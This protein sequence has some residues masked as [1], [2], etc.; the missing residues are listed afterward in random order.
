MRSVAVQWGSLPGVPG[1][2]LLST[3]ATAQ[4]Q[5]ASLTLCCGSFKS[6][7]FILVLKSH[8][9]C[10]NSPCVLYHCIARSS[11]YSV[12]FVVDIV[13]PRLFILSSRERLWV[14]RVVVPQRCTSWVMSSSLF[15]LPHRHPLRGCGAGS[16]WQQAECWGL[17]FSRCLWTCEQ[18]WSRPHGS[19]TRCL[20]LPMSR[21]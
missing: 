11:C 9:L 10:S 21:N 15:A 1:G 19:G 12:F 2:G 5:A 3:P 7:I 17:G 20:D 6:P 14:G 13:L 4:V 8:S 18:Q 16:N